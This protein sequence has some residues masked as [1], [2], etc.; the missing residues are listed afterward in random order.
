MFYTHGVNTMH[1]LQHEF[2]VILSNFGNGNY[3]FCVP[4]DVTR[5]YGAGERTRVRGTIDGVGYRGTLTLLNGRHYLTVNRAMRYAIGKSGGDTLHVVIAPDHE[6]RVVELPED[7]IWALDANAKAKAI[8]DKF[9]YS[10]RRQVV[11]WIESARK[12]ETRA[13][14]VQE[15]MKRIVS[16]QVEPVGA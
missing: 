5:M 10:H 7:L 12:A 1:P 9:G 6:P 14:R 2:S 15:A 3:G 16:E 4:F 13:Y 8:F 11:N